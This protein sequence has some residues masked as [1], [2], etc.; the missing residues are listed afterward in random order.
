LKDLFEQETISEDFYLYRTVQNLTSI[1]KA[2]DE[3]INFISSFRSSPERT[4]YEKSMSNLKVGRSGDNYID[5]IVHWE[6]T[7]ADEF[8]KLKNIMKEL[9]LLAQIKTNRFKGGRF[10]V[11]VK[12]SEKSV[13]STLND[14]GFGISQ[15]LP[16]IVSDLQ[17]DQKSTLFVAQ[18][19]I[20]LHPSVQ[21]SFADYIVEQIINSNKRYIIE[22]HSE[23][24]LNRIRLA[25]VQSKIK[26]E[27]VR[28]YYFQND[29]EISKTFEIKIKRNG[30]IEDAPEDFFKTYQMDIMDI[31]LSAE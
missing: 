26:E 10:E 25:I 4:Y 21:A 12:T 7:N 23:Y 15:F 3:E 17:L 2:F 27:N 9:S 1:F 20:H 18:P 11:L 16:I 28:A 29:G 14:V 6:S 19:E 24:F 5:Q 31:A 22:T 8:K 13:M 30:T